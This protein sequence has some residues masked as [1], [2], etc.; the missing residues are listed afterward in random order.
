M[1]TTHIFSVAVFSAF[2]FTLIFWIDS[3]EALWQIRTLTNK[4]KEIASISIPV[5][6]GATK[7][8]SKLG[9]SGDLVVAI[10]GNGLMTFK[11]MGHNT[12]CSRPYWGVSI[13]YQ[14]KYWGLF[15]D[16]GGTIDVTI[17]ADGTAS[18][19]AGPAGQIVQGSGPP[20]CSQR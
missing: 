3:S 14:G 10:P 16:G 5:G 1:K 18:F 20:I 2:L 6:P 4:T 13:N 9:V 11:D 15:Y 7:Q 17:N 19:T 12:P 8:S